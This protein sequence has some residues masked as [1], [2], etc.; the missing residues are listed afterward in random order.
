M[1][2]HR[3]GFTLIEVLVAVSIIGLLASII[4]VFVQDARNRAQVASGL[5]FNHSVDTS[6]SDQTAA[7][8]DFEEE[9]GNNT[10]S[11]SSGNGAAG[12]LH[13]VTRTD[14]GIQGRAIALSGVDS[15]VAG[16]NLQPGTSITVT[17][18]VYPQNTTGPKQVFNQGTSDC[19]SYGM[20][21]SGGKMTSEKVGLKKV[22]GSSPVIPEYTWSYL[23]MVF[24]QDG[25]VNS[26]INGKSVGSTLDPIANCNTSN[27]T[28]GTQPVTAASSEE[29]SIG[30]SEGFIG[31][32][33]KVSIFHTAL[34]AVAV[35]KL[36]DKEKP[37]FFARK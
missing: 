19:I 3:K 12:T 7:A 15:Y 34:T 18:W 35:G 28:I 9:D 4:S 22:I 16:S 26:Y 27:W 13:N 33:D 6:L 32:I 25:T 24:E 29:M 17:A 11:D 2:I 23:T 14:N 31:K 1:R 37:L 5:E 20:S 36:Y 21:L 8:W 30:S 10:V